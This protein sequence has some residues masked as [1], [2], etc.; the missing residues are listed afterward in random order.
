MQDCRRRYG[1]SKY[2]R[3]AAP[4]GHLIGAINGAISCFG[5]GTPTGECRS[6]LAEKLRSP[7]TAA[8]LICGAAVTRL[9]KTWPIKCFLRE[10][11][12]AKLISNIFRHS[13]TTSEFFLWEKFVPSPRLGS[14]IK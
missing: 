6:G 1:R 10:P 11:P 5:G 13:V 12:P 2:V 8:T 9:V 14:E 7:D 3:H 4:L